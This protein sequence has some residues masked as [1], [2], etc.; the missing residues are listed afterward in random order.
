MTCEYCGLQ[1]LTERCNRPEGIEA[2]GGKKLKMCE[3]AIGWN[4]CDPD[5]LMKGRRRGYLTTKEVLAGPHR[6]GGTK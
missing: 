2:R 5:Q 6:R 4:S 1:H 3:Q